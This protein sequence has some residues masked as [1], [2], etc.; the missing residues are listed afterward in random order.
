MRERSGRGASRGSLRTPRKGEKDI[1]P[2][3][4]QRTCQG[5]NAQPGETAKP[6]HRQNRRRKGAWGGGRQGWRKAQ[7]DTGAQRPG[8]RMRRG[9]QSETETSGPGR[10]GKEVPAGRWWRSRCAAP[11]GEGCARSGARGGGAAAREWGRRGA[12]LVWGFTSGLQTQ[13]VAVALS[14][15]LAVVV[16]AAQRERE[17]R[18]RRLRRPGG[19]RGRRG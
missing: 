1:S 4:S 17:W 19:G 5:K 9:R 6:Y 11:R 2:M 10:L 12:G 7:L 13:P 3:Q 18:W 16:V 15:A 14:V 8:A